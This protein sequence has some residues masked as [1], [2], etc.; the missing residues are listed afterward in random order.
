MPTP[1]PLEDAIEDIIAKAQR[2]LGLNDLL[3]CERA[4]VTPGTLNS[5]REGTADRSA[6]KAL[7]QVLKLNPQALFT[8]ANGNWQPAIPASTTLTVFSS[9]YRSMLVNA[10]LIWDAFTNKAVL[11]DT[12]MQA[13]PILDF[14]RG[15][16]LDLEAIILTHTHPDHIGALEQLERECHRPAIYSPAEE[17]IE[18]TLQVEEGQ[19][20]RL[21]RL[22]IH[23]LLT[24]GHSPGGMSYRIE[25]LSTTTLICGDALFAGSIGRVSPQH[26]ALALEA[27]RKKILSLPDKTVICP[28][29]GPM[30]TVGEEKAHNPFFA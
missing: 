14:L 30:T 12:G 28:G 22:E 5:A 20:F 27:I 2:G 11:F 19:K 18:G 6:Y 16:E 3:L 7:S 10:Y 26:Y 4:D 29:H 1:L 24:P 23:P 25:G 13:I 17:S 21:G 15:Q 8:I 9:E